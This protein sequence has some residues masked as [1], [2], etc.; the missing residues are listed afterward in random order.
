MIYVDSVQVTITSITFLHKNVKDE[1]T[2]NPCN[3]AK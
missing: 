2:H 3:A 1:K